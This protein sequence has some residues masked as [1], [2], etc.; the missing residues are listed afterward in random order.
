MIAVVT[1]L[2]AAQWSLYP[3]VLDSYYHLSVI[4]GFQ[5]AGGPVL[6]SFWEAAPE[7]QPHLYPPLFHLLWLPI[8]LL[9]VPPM[10]LA[11]LWSCTA[12]TLLLGVAWLVF[13]Q[14]AT[15]RSAFLIL[16]ALTT[17]FTFFVASAS[18][19]PAT[20]A[21]ACGLGLMLATVKKRWRAGGLLLALAF[22]LHAGLPW[23]FVLTLILFAILEPEFRKTIRAILGIG[24]LGASPWLLHTALHFSAVQFHIGGEALLVD[25]SPLLIG[26]GI[27][28]FKICW[29]R[30]R[31]PIR[32]LCAMTLGF[33]PILFTYNSRYMSAQ[34]LFCWLLLAGV[35]LERLI[36][37]IRHRWLTIPAVTLLALAAPG[38]YWLPGY[39]FYGAWADTTFVA[40]AGEPRMIPR[41]VFKENLLNERFID[42]FAPSVLHHTNPSELIYCNYPYIAGMMSVRTG[43]S[44]TV[45][46]LSEIAQ[47][48]TEQQIRP[49]KLIFWIKKPGV[50]PD[51]DLD[52]LLQQ[53][54]LRLL[55]TTWIANIYENPFPQGSRRVRRALLPW[56]LAEGFLLLAVGGIIWDF[57][58]DR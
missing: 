16:V 40:L 46:M 8:S 25:T 29:D 20:L 31:D 49:A 42:E 44:T 36:Q 55:K 33:L 22:W 23:L 26:L 24:L 56:W 14:L 53:F 18:Y 27:W 5:E 48:P 7:G 54:H 41:G 32:F 38:I 28:G 9:G 57:R 13:S 6:H 11:R 58:R 52:R 35:A 15:A 50:Q 34:G 3:Y 47:R 4:Q 12:L 39:L 19:L 43:R 30:E 1:L 21:Q 45:Q 10:V 17:P 51:P 37:K 2:A